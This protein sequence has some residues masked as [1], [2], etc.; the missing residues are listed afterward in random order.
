MG[1]DWK[2]KGLTLLCFMLAAGLAMGLTTYVDTYSVREWSEVLNI[3]PVSM[4]VEGSDVENH[5]EDIQ[6]INGVEKA[7]SVAY[8]DGFLTGVEKPYT[9]TVTAPTSGFYE[10]FPTLLPL[11]EGR[12]PSN[13]SEIAVDEEKARELDFQVGETV[14]CTRQTET[15]KEGERQEVEVT[16]SFLIVGIFER[17]QG[18]YGDEY[19]ISLKA[20]TS[21]IALVHPEAIPEEMAEWVVY[22]DIDKSPLT[23]FDVRGSMGFVGNIQSEIK[24]VDPNYDPTEWTHDYN[25]NSRLLSS[26]QRY[27]DWLNAVRM[28]QLSRAGGLILLIALLNFIAVRHNFNEREYKALLLQARGASKLDTEK[29]IIREIS[30]L[31]VAGTVL[32]LFFGILLSRFAISSTGYLQFDFSLF[33]TEPFLIS[34]E[35]LFLSLIVGLLVPFFTMGGYF[36]VYRLKEPVQEAGGKLEKMIEGF[37]TIQWDAILLTIASLVLAS[38]YLFGTT[39]IENQNL[40][41][42]LS[43]MPFVLFVS[44]SSLVIKGLRWGALRISKTFEGLIG[45]LP[46]SIGIR[47]IGKKASSAAPVVIVLALSMSLAWNMAI[48]DASLPVTKENHAKFAFGGDISFSLDNAA[49]DSWDSFFQNVS[50]YPST[51][52]TSLVSTV[53]VQVSAGWE[54][55][56]SLT[57]INPETFA[58]VGYDYR[59]TRLNESTILSDLLESLQA[60]TSTV[61]ITEYLAEKYDL[62]AGNIIHASYAENEHDAQVFS[63]AVGGIVAGLSDM[64]EAT[65]DRSGPYMHS[66]SKR[67]MWVNREAI[68]ADINLT[69]RAESSLCVATKPGVNETQ[70]ASE[71]LEC[72]ASKVL[73]EGWGAE[74]GWTAVSHEVTSYVNQ[75]EYTM[76]RAADTL[77]AVGTLF[78]IAGV[79]I[80][81]TIEDIRSWK[82]EVALLRSNGGSTSHV[83]KTKAAELLLLVLAGIGLLLAS[84]PVLTASS[85]L[86]LRKTRLTFPIR[87]FIVIP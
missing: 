10:A 8:T 34:L 87:F 58:K 79:F 76:D 57:G 3:G 9:E 85:L 31:S 81:Y 62:E 72:G 86:L 26:I 48:V 18:V 4:A 65:T 42:A 77:V 11:Q 55:R 54:G 46:S 61:I 41:I 75:T 50:T 17:S 22:V 16:D 67:V 30:L 69:A 43:A 60:P 23:P 52:Q 7:A 66:F 83:M 64:S 37:K 63:F 38:M 33:R 51:Y 80:L 14:N 5:V 45:K 68:S 32:G 35:S 2:R 6:A 24:Q 39:S 20:F 40:R 53:D 25:I 12:Y 78:V 84:A 73:K 28:R 47:K 70:M 1:R 15:Y 13:T 21:V 29:A 19:A 36:A 49:A 82:R 71:L 27:M 59:G 44:L 56:V 74:E